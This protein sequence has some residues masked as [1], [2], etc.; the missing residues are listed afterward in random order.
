M[1]K[2][3]ILI[4]ALALIFASL[5]LQAVNAAVVNYKFTV[6]NYMPDNINITL[7]STEKNDDDEYD[8]YDITVPRADEKTKELPKGDYTYVYEAC[9]TV[10]SG[11]LKLKKDVEWEIYPCGVEPSKMRYNSHF[12]EKITVTMYGP[13]EMPDPDEQEIVVELGGNPVPD[14]LSGH[15]TISYEAACSTVA[16]D[17]KTV[18]T[19]EI[20]VLKNGT[21]QITLH[22]CEWYA[23]PARIYEKPVPVK[24]Q[25]INHASFPLILQIVG[26]EGALLDINPGVNTFTLIYGTYKYGYFMDGIYYTGY[27][28]VTKN[29]LGQLVLKP[30]HIFELPTT[31]GTAED[32]GG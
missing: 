9:N 29:G 28:M 16:A 11:T 6:I 10:Y 22:G 23:S 24:F 8:V 20:R 12:A 3:V 31:G 1:K 21:T 15:Y 19:E 17:P 30:S 32:N 14:I 27:M 25:V 13:L 5:P 18:F 7:T 4:V 2:T 26:P